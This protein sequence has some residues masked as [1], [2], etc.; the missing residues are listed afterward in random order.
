M[1]MGSIL[2]L[3]NRDLRQTSFAKED[4]GMRR[5]G[6]STM[7]IL[8][9]SA[10]AMGWTAQVTGVS[11]DEG[12][13][14]TGPYTHD[15]LAIYLIHRESS[16]SGA[17]PLTLEEAMEQGVVKVIE[18]G[19]IEELLVRNLG[20]REVFIQAGDIV[21]GGK[22]DRVLVVS[23]VLPP[24]SGDIPIGA[25]CVEHGRWAGRGEEET[26]EFSASEALM[27]SR[28]A[29]MAIAEQAR[30]ATALAPADAEAAQ[31]TAGRR[32]LEGESL[33]Y[34]V[35][36][37]VR[38]MQA[39]LSKAI[40]LEVAD[41]RSPSSLQLSLENAALASALE[42]FAATLGNLAQ[43]HPGAVGYVF[44]IN[45]KI[46]GGDEFGSAGLF[47]KLWLRQLKAASTEAIA[48]EDMPVH[49]QPT[50]AEV[51]AFIDDVRAA[52]PMGKSMPGRMSLEVRET[53]KAL[54][55]EIRRQNGR[56]VHRS[57]VAYP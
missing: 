12:Y 21:K 8:A 7:A 3:F 14:L 2:Q 52:E 6:F 35:W 26:A 41:E 27:P 30:R 4:S 40:G 50:L 46:N 9:V 51:T 34:E 22:Q 39:Y 42:D 16:D 36:D 45:G 25:F 19:D 24:N 29:R 53:P 23:M 28:A 1:W 44:A 57:F 10:I 43:E 54:Y 18:T 31:P 56:W 33:Q 20:R 32:Q 11:A 48:E 13:Q 37:S 55:S 15:N 38:E 5:H 47:R 17:V 49:D